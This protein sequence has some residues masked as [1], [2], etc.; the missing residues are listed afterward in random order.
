MVTMTMMMA[1][2]HYNGDND[3]YDEYHIAKNRGP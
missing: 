2:G 1:E 3:W